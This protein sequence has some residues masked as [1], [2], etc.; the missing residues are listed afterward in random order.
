MGGRM[1]THQIQRRSEFASGATAGIISFNCNGSISLL[2]QICKI[3]VCWFVIRVLIFHSRNLSRVYCHRTLYLSL[4]PGLNIFS[5]TT[6]NT[7]EPNLDLY[8]PLKT[9][10]SS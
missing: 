7:S 1:L 9:A 8:Y 3:F 4:T 10:I 5:S 2:A 6:T